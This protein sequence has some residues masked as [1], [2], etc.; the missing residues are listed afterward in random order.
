MVN[1]VFGCPTILRS[2]G[3]IRNIILLPSDQAA[4]AGAEASDPAGGAGRESSGGGHPAVHGLR[5][6]GRGAQE[7]ED[8][9]RRG[10]GGGRAGG[11]RF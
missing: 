10:G 3:W 7:E 9:G 5:G 8:R 2:V 1:I 4:A 11:E 6:R